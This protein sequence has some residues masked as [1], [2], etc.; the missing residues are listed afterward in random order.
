M[1]WQIKNDKPGTSYALSADRALSKI[2]FLIL[3]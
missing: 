2:S 3:G 1:E